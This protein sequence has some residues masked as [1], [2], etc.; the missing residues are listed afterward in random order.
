M[1]RKKTETTPSIGENKKVNVPLIARYLPV[2][3]AQ[4]AD[5]IIANDQTGAEQLRTEIHD[6]LSFQ[7]RGVALAA[8]MALVDREW[9]LAQ[10]FARP[11]I[12]DA[13]FDDANE[14]TMRAHHHGDFARGYPPL[15]EPEPETSA[16]DDE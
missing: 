16:L 15:G 7:F 3:V 6:Q 4:M 9:K 11:A 2:A 13:A 14:V 12:V 5:R 1:P 8:L 10:V